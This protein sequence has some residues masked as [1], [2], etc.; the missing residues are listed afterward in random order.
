MGAGLELFGRRKDGS[1]VAVEI[2]LS[3]M[4]TES[5]AWVITAI[6]DVTD[7]VRMAEELSS[8]HG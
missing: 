2:S 5:G 1:E 3:P 6:R 4:E 7:R 8:D